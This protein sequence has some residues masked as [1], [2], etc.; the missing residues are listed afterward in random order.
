MNIPCPTAYRATLCLVVYLALC[1][2]AAAFAAEAGEAERAPADIY[3][4]NLLTQYEERIVGRRLAYLYE[5]RH[6]LVQDAEMQ[7]RLDRIKAR[8]RAVIPQPDLEIKII[9]SAQP[10]AV[11]FP[12][13]YIYITSTLVRLV[14]TD[15]ELAAVIAHEAA[16]VANHHL[17]RLIALALALP[18][19]EQERFPTRRA[20]VTGQAIQFAFPSMLD[21]AR[22]GCEIEADKWAVV[23]MARA[24]YAGQSL[25]L[26]LDSLTARLPPQARSEQIALRARITLLREETLLGFR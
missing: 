10:E 14:A 8:L 26:L 24:G 12:P 5:Q 21:D 23:W 2:T 17:S 13:G 19:S 4:G 3:R 20:I 6:T 7:A 25:A 22:L 15:D 16:H 18:L 11:S 9:R 1:T